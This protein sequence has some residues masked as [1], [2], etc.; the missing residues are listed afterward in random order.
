MGDSPIFMPK[1]I[2][3]FVKYVDRFNRRIGRLAMLLIYAMMGVLLFSSLTRTFFDMSFIWIVE[4]AQFLMAAY[5]LLGGAYSI[6]LESHVRMD[7]LYSRWSIKGKATMDVI[8]ACFLIFYLIYLFAGGITSTEYAIT[9]GQKNYSSWAPPLWP[10]KSIMTFG[11]FLMLL[12]SISMFFKDYAA[13]RG[14][15]FNEL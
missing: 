3:Y 6:Q 10:I 9:Y 11:V 1:A 7:L 15:T 13:A 5:Y 14:K 2:V 12:Q 8:T 4:S